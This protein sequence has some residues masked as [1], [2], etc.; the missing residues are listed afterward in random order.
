LDLADG[1]NRV[2]MKHAEYR[3]NVIEAQ[4]RL[5][6]DRGMRVKPER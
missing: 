6:H 3:T 2:P 5:M 4:I 1:A